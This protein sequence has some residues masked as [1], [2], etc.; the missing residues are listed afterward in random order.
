MR[1]V[2]SVEISIHIINSKEGGEIS[3]DRDTT[4]QRIAAFVD[5]VVRKKIPADHL[6]S[7]VIG[8]KK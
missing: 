6:C 1:G 8:L 5:D 7:L 4:I 2:N 3:Y